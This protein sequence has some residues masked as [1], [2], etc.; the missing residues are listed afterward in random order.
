[1][2]GS[3]ALLLPCGLTYRAI[4]C[5]SQLLAR[6]KHIGALLLCELH[7]G[8]CGALPACSLVLQACTQLSTADCAW[9]LLWL[10]RV[11]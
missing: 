4:Q 1:M 11:V 8:L 3:W 5:F 7:G 2:R 10:V 6:L 9:V